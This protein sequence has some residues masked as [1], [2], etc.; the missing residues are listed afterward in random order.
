MIHLY[1]AKPDS[2][3]I[4]ATSIKMATDWN[5]RSPDR[6]NMCGFD[7]KYRPIIAMPRQNSMIILST[8]K[9]SM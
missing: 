7:K 1:T 4:I 6:R 9:V 3:S 8:E 2:T 5:N